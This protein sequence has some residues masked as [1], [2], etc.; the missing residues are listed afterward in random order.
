[1]IQ[2]G[3]GGDPDGGSSW[4]L[5]A[6]I[7]CCATVASRPRRTVHPQNPRNDPAQ[8]L[9]FRPPYLQIRLMTT[10]DLIPLV[11]A[12]LDVPAA[13][14]TQDSGPENVPQWDSL[15]HITVITAV[16]KAYQIQLTVPEMLE[17]QSI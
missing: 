6:G 13:S 9:T 4:V 16:E 15:A 1:R 10:D 17:S 2:T 7:V 12:A 8:A 14:L 5:R 11:A 3:V